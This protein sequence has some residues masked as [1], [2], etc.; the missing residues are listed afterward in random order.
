MPSWWVTDALPFPLCISSE[1]DEEHGS[2]FLDRVS[3]ARGNIVPADHGRTIAAEELPPVPA[4]PRQLYRPI[5]QEGPLNNAAP[6]PLDFFPENGPPQRWVPAASLAGYTP[7]QAEPSVTLV[8][9]G[10]EAWVPRRD[11]LSSD[12]FSQHLVAEM[13][14]D[15][16]A[17]LRFGDEVNGKA[18]AGGTV[19]QA[20]YRVGNGSAGN[21]GRDSLAHLVDSGIPAGIQR[22]RNP[23]PALGGRDPEALEEARRYAPQAFR[24]QL[25]AVTADDYARVAERHPEVSRAVASFRLTAS[26]HTV[27]VSIDRAGG[28]GVDEEFQE[29]I[30]NHLNRFRLAGYDLEIRP[31]RFVPLDVKLKICLAEGYFR[32][33]VARALLRAFSNCLLPDGSLGFFHPD[34]WTFGQPIYL[35]RLYR[36][37]DAIP[38][39]DSAHVERFKRWGRVAGQELE[40]GLIEM[41]GFEIARLDND[42]SLR[43]NGLLELELEGGL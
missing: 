22:I 41:G 6:L 11:L 4:D 33:D 3:I 10:G 13:E 28:L 27:F 2:R 5:L 31:P 37:A 1:T 39:V 34:N 24:V 20:H 19:F 17:R 12:A 30:R 16:R 36:V 14:D 15:G 18:P 23:L 38:G 8:T 42:P 25:R 7:S 21:L 35:S 40:E 29:E 9:G 26:W 43:E 32:S